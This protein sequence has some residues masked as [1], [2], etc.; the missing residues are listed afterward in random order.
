MHVLVYAK[1]GQM[2]S[3]ALLLGTK[4]IQ[5]TQNKNNNKKNLIC[6]RVNSQVIH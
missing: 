6:Y 2:K 4:D 1:K 5:K 3:V